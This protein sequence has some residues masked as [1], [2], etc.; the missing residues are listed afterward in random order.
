[1]LVYMGD[2]TGIPKEKVH[3]HSFR[4]LFALTYM[5]TY[6]NVAEWSDIWGISHK[7][8]DAATTVSLIKSGFGVTSNDRG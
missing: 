2:M 7:N 8:S 5:D 6:G 1:M 4:H 3:P